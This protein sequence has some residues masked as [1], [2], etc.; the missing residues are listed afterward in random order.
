MIVLHFQHDLLQEISADAETSFDDVNK[1]KDSASIFFEE[2]IAEHCDF[3]SANH[4]ESQ[5]DEM[6]NEC[7]SRYYDFDARGSSVRNSAEFGQLAL[8]EETA[9]PVHIFFEKDLDQVCS[10]FESNEYVAP[11]SK[12]LSSESESMHE[13]VAV[14]YKKSRL[15]Y[16]VGAMLPMCGNIRSPDPLHLTSILDPDPEQHSLEDQLDGEFRSHTESSG[17]STLTSDRPKISSS[18]G[19]LVYCNDD[20][21]FRESCNDSSRIMLPTS[22]EKR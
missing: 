6:Q 13:S 21:K 3:K 9:S 10:N 7:I 8:N 18:N 17:E 5:S 4:D 19:S 14:S 22:D 20:P 1:T 2:Y 11:S 16:N 12:T 15:D